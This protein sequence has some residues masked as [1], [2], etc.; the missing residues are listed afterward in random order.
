VP[1]STT[2][3]VAA[4]SE[5]QVQASAESSGGPT[6]PAESSPRAAAEAVFQEPVWGGWFQDAVV[7]LFP[8]AP[9]S[10][11]PAGGT[12]E[13]PPKA[14]GDPG[15]LPGNPSDILSG[16]GAQASGQS[17]QSTSGSNYAG[18]FDT[19]NE[20]FAMPERSGLAGAAALPVGAS[21]PM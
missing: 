16:A 8:S 9:A 15:A 5:S 11:L 4:P 6:A 14:S 21:S 2:I 10:S 7:S 18:F 12:V 3:T 19:G 17:E 1:F 20:V 13:E